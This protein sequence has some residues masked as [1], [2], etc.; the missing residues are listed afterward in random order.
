MQ[1]AL[2]EAGLS[3]E[4]TMPPSPTLTAERLESRNIAIK[5]EIDNEYPQSLP[6]PPSHDDRS[7]SP[8]Q[9]DFVSSS[10]SSDMT[11]HPAEML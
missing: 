8:G 1:K 4:I 2:K 9:E 11:Q 5:Q 7:P 6:T 10:N 3:C